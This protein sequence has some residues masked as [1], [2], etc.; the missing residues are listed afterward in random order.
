MKLVAAILLLVLA[1]GV[2]AGTADDPEITDPAADTG[3]H[4]TVPAGLEWGD[5]VKLWFEP[6]E[7]DRTLLTIEVVEIAY[8][9]PGEVGVVVGV[10]QQHYAV[11]WTTVALP[12]ANTPGS[13]ATG[14]YQGGFACQSDETGSMPDTTTCTTLNAT[15]EGNRYIVEMPWEF[16]GLAP[17][18]SLDQPSGYA[19]ELIGSQPGTPTVDIEMAGPG[20][21]Y[22][23][24]VEATVA[25]NQTT[26]SLTVAAPVAVEPIE[27]DHDAPG[28]PALAMVCSLLVCSLLIR[29]SSK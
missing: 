12:W 20:R 28:L 27:P 15:I 1:P 25:A 13:P 7:G 19:T 17:G 14:L 8:G 26:T 24:P 29:R 18:L 2:V 16:F 10:N 22:T 11:G 4:L 21:S 6:G 3:Y 23:L 9:P 5:I